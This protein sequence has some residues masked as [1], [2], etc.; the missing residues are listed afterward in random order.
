MDKLRIA[1][2]LV[3]YVPLMFV[4]GYFS[5][6]PR[7]QVTQPDEA[8]VRVSFSHAAQ[9]LQECRQR[10]DEELAKLPPNMR[11][12]EDCPRERAPTHFQLEIDGELRVDRVIVPS[13]L[14]RDGPAP[15]YSRLTVPA[16][17]HSFVARLNDSPASGF[18]HSAEATIDLKPG[19]AVVID[20]QPSKG[21]FIFST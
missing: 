20:F 12:R 21:G 19:D 8:L 6:S 2:Q 13:G 16:G 17:R 10:S 1:A 3:L 7:Y 9:R 15:L 18:A 11:V 4:V 5:T 14:N